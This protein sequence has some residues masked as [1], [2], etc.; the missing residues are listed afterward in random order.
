M[1]RTMS[2]LLV[3]SDI[4]LLNVSLAVTVHQ[5]RFQTLLV[6]E[7]AHKQELQINIKDMSQLQISDFVRRLSVMINSRELLQVFL[8]NCE[9]N[10][11][12][13]QKGEGSGVWRLL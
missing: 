10:K 7:S 5:E 12:N 3:N 8:S 1:K 6:L 4:F 13:G 11:I 2:S 9:C